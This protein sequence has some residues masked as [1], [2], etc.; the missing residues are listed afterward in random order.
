MSRHTL[1]V[2]LLLGAVLGTLRADDPKAPPAPQKERAKTEGKFVGTWKGKVDSFDEIW[3]IKQTDGTWSVNGKYRRNGAEAGSFV[4][5]DI[6]EADGTLSFTRKYVKKPN[7]EWRDEAT[8]VVKSEGENLS[9]T[10]KA[11]GFEGRRALEKVADAEKP[12]EV[13]KPKDDELGL[14][15]GTWTADVATGFRVVMQITT[16]NDKIDISANYYNKK[17]QPAGSF[18]AVDPVVK[19]GQLTF[20]QHFVQKP[21]SSWNDGKLHTLEMVS[22]NVLKFSWKNG[23]TENFARV[24]K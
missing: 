2:L 24:K 15:R 5:T 19:N 4:G 20:S 21:V 9:Y 17:G 23:G 6:K 11:G 1:P 13:E 16:K 22:D 8:V 18:V 7:P 10:W 12:K 3:T 14:F